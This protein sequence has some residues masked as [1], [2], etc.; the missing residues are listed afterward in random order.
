MM[1]GREREGG[2][3][4]T[5]FCKYCTAVTLAH[6]YLV[7]GFLCGFG[8]HKSIIQTKMYKNL[9]C[10]AQNRKWLSDSD[11]CQLSAVGCRGEL[12][13]QS[14]KLKDIPAAFYFRS[15]MTLTAEKR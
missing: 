3:A 4:H 7:Y 5:H 12:K 15:F 2:G 8:D 6:N 1:C 11:N 14:S 9:S 10:D 13:T